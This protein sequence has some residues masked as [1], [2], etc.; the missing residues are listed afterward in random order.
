[1]VTMTS[2][3]FST[4]KSSGYR[5]WST[6]NLQ[7]GKLPDEELTADASRS[8]DRNHMSRSHDRSATSKSH[9]QNNLRL[10][11][12]HNSRGQTQMDL[13]NKNLYVFPGEVFMFQRLEVLKLQNNQLE[14]LPLAISRLRSLRS[15]HL[16]EN[17][18]TFLP[19][20]LSNCIHLLEINLTKNQLAGII[21]LFLCSTQLNIKFKLL[22][23]IKPE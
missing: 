17:N 6:R 23:N 20:T 7:G 9:D 3:T 19:E 22:I 21:K 18:L 4:L 2:A 5:S 1:M 12:I 8:H 14:E 15:L 16:Q 13:S 10:Q 11:L